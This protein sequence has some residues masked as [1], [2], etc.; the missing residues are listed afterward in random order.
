[1]FVGRRYINVIDH[2]FSSVPVASLMYRRVGI[3]P[4]EESRIVVIITGTDS[5]S[6][7]PTRERRGIELY[8]L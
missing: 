1:M 5:H 6:G 8:N 3:G 7:G 2:I 4:S